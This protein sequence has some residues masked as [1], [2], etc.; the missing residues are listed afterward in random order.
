MERQSMRS[1]SK[2]MGQENQAQNSAQTA[3][4]RI[5]DEVAALKT[6][7]KQIVQ[8][9]IPTRAADDLTDWDLEKREILG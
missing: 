5:K 7:R 2:R 4:S 8:Q 6:R 9:E 3:K 1:S